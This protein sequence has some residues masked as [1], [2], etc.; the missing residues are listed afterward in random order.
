MVSFLDKSICY[1]S[2]IKVGHA[3]GNHGEVALEL[4]KLYARTVLVC[5]YSHL[6]SLCSA[7]AGE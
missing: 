3:T 7:E 6:P 5:V 2:G 4:P 1:V